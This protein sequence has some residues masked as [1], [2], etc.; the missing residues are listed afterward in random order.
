MSFMLLWSCL[1][2]A[3]FACLC[4]GVSA[5]STGIHH[6]VLKE[7]LFSPGAESLPKGIHAYTAIGIGIARKISQLQIVLEAIGNIYIYICIRI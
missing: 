3:L 7:P 5:V 4:K 6:S 2:L 1:C